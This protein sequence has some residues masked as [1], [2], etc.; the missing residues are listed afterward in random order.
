M[1]RLHAL[2][3]GCASLAALGMAATSASAA[4]LPRKAPPAYY[5][6]AFS[7]TGFY[8]GING[9]YGWTTSFPSKAD[10]A[11][12]GGQLG[13]NWQIGSFVVGLEGDF[14]GTSIK[15]SET[16]AP[17][18]IGEAKIPAFATVRGR[19]GYAWNSL[20]LYA[21]GG[22]AYTQSKASLSAGG[23]SISDS[24]WGSGYAIGG[25]VE[26]ALWDRWSVKGEYLYLKSGDTT[27]TL[28][29]FTQS[30]D[31]KYNVVRAGLN[32]RF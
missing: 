2:F 1:K 16:V 4:D 25:G 8:A 11:V 27:L 23:L 30:I 17:G 29:G 14:Q 15:Y 6:P 28:A 24:S 13:Y 20:L 10:G 9:G 18:V 19:V 22:W 7:W 32:Y 3:L 21:T 31:Y 26:Y 12:Y 5:A